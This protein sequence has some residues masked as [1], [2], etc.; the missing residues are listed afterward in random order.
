M[1]LEHADYF[2][3]EK[4]SCYCP[5]LEIYHRRANTLLKITTRGSSSDTITAKTQ[6]RVTTLVKRLN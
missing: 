6:S 3:E 5:V 2:D 1:E 4:M